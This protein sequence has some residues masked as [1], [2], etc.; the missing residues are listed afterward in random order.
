MYSL[1][2]RIVESIVDMGAYEFCPWA[3]TCSGSNNGGG[4]LPVGGL[5][6]KQDQNQSFKEINIYPNPATNI[7]NIKSESEIVSISLLNVQGQEVKRW[8][9][10]NELYIGDIP[11]GL[12][13]LK[14]NTTEGT[15][16]VRI[17]KE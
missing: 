11:I 3:G 13:L 1:T 9:A 14:I 8:N 16:Q 15:E 2:Y 17:I 12:Y 10:K 7:L 5:K 6:I 4:H